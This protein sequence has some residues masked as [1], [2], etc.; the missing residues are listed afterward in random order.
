LKLHSSDSM[1]GGP[2]FMFEIKC[3]GA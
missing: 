1:T 2:M 3:F